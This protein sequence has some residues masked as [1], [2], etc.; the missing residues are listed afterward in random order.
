MLLVIAFVCFLA[1]A[2]WSATLRSWPMV[3]LAAGLAV[4]VVEVSG[5]IRIG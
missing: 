2:I 3:L 1:S 4:W 5:P